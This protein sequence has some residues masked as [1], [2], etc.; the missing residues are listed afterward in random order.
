MPRSLPGHCRGLNKKHTK[1]HKLQLAAVCTSVK[2]YNIMTVLLGYVDP[3]LG[4]L[5]WQSTV[6]A[7]IGVLFYFK[8]TRR[9]AVSFFQ[10]LFRL[11]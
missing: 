1:N 8:K 9:W 7:F 2:I 5:V 4:A 6:S 11:K 10:K 3:G